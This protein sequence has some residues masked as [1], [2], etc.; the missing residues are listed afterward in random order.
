MPWAVAAAGLAVASLGLP[1]A[2]AASPTVT[3]TSTLVVGDGDTVRDTHFVWQGP[4]D[5]PVI[6][7]SGT[8]GA[9]LKHL[10]IEVPDGFH[11][12]AAIEFADGPVGG[13][14]GNDVSD[15]RVG[16]YFLASKL[17]Y[18]LLWSGSADGGGNTITN[19][20]IETAEVA[21]FAIENPASASNSFRGVYS[22]L[23]PIGFESRAAGDTVC[24]NCGFIAS[25]TVDVNLLDGAGL[26]II[27]MY[28]EDGHAFA[29]LTAGPAGGG[30]SVTG[31]YW[32]WNPHALAT[33]SI[34]GTNTGGYRTFVRLTD[35]MV[36]PLDSTCHGSIRGFAPEQLFIDNSWGITTE[37]VAGGLTRPFCNNL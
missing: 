14:F 35:F 11:G 31:G 8:H 19:V 7:L 23:S 24:T 17:S 29:S 4:S 13:P 1:A 26:R 32:M 33:A 18:G 15:V 21:A 34:T 12:K 25:T 5:A 2:H 6:L 10:F 28:S 36:T 20:S 37:I 9:K 27:G 22:I 3:L 16:N 30:L